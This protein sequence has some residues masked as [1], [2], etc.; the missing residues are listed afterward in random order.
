MD[1][2]FIRSE[3]ITPF[4][5]GFGSYFVLR[6]WGKWRGCI[7]TILLAWVSFVYFGFIAVMIYNSPP[8]YITVCL[9]GFAVAFSARFLRFVGTV[10]YA[11]LYR[12]QDFVYAIADRRR[13]REWQAEYDRRRG[14]FEEDWQRRAY[15]AEAERARRE[16]EARQFRE[17]QNRQ[18][19]NQ[20]RDR[21]E[22]RSEQKQGYQREQERKEQRY[23][24]EPPK[25]TRS[26]AEILGLSGSWTKEELKTAYKRESQR[27]HPDRWIGKP[28]V[29][30][31]AMEEEFK[32]IQE[33]YNNLNK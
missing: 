6:L 21:G 14:Q 2:S 9:V 27:T 8:V 17:R 5:F 22:D 20:N 18:K 13:A 28:E 26:Y 33:A 31:K 15:E 16:E 23:E 24:P 30:R 7:L 3:F 10:W 12:I 32:R 1:L 19:Q 25:D 4:M 11:V 29:V